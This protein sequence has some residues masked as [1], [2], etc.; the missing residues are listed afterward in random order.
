VQVVL[1]AKFLEDVQ[2]FVT[3]VL[4]GIHE[5]LA[6]AT[7][8]MGIFEALVEHGAQ[9]GDMVYIGKNSFEFSEEPSPQL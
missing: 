8:G 6:E 2:C 3:S 7:D 1:L 4:R 9:P 5:R